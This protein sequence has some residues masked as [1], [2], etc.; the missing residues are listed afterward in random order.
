MRSSDGDEEVL[1]VKVVITIEEGETRTVIPLAEAQRTAER[2]MAGDASLES[3]FDGGSAR[4][5]IGPE[6][7]FLQTPTERGAV[8]AMDAGPAPIIDVDGQTGALRGS[9][10][11]A[12]DE[13][14][15]G[16][17]EGGST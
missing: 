8:S 5:V 14:H 12:D 2:G 17:A 7:P 3:P 15:S 4:A 6:E 9:P 13:S 11:L 16:G 1:V 10:E